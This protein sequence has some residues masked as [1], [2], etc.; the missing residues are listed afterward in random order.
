MFKEKVNTWTDA[1]LTTD[2]DIS[3]LAYGQW[4]LKVT[5]WINLDRQRQ[6]C[7][8]ECAHIHRNAIV[9]TMSCSWRVGST[10]TV[11][12]CFSCSMYI[13]CGLRII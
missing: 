1:R 8:Q 9:T 4:S 7:M 6:A 5:V 13:E 3:L 11:E 2:H 12:F 10:E